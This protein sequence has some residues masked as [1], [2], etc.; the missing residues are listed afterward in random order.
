MC[1]ANGFEYPE[2][3]TKIPSWD[4]QIIEYGKLM[5]FG[6]ARY[7][8]FGYIAANILGGLCAAYPVY[9]LGEYFARLWASINP[10]DPPP[11]GGGGP[12]DE[13]APYAS[14]PDPV[15]GFEEFANP[16]DEKPEPNEMVD[17]IGRDGKIQFAKAL[18]DDTLYVDP[19][20]HKV[21][22]REFYEAMK[23]G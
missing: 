11:G 10:G 9:K 3:A 14:I 23:K 6:L 7:T 21:W 4:T 2:Q 5:I 22:D 18:N 13:D 8:V 16:L 15:E 19:E 1:G 20:T 17:I 12:L